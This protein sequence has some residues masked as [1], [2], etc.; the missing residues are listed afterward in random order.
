[1]LDLQGGGQ[2]EVYLVPP[3]AIPASIALVGRGRIS[4]WERNI[5]GNIPAGFI[6]ELDQEWEQCS[7]EVGR[8]LPCPGN[9]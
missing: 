6:R 3:P 9:T 2:G 8:Q 4:E 1:M 7:R 5:R